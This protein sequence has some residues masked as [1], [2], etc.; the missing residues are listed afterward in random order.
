MTERNSSSARRTRDETRQCQERAYTLKTYGGLSFDAIAKQPD[1]TGRSGS[2]YANASSA[3]AAYLAQ[4]QRVQGTDREPALSVTERRALTDD[5]YERLIQSLLPKAITGNGEAADRVLRAMAQQA[6]LHGL[7]VRPAAPAI[8][9][10]K[11]GDPADEL[12]ERRAHA[13][14]AATAALR[15]AAPAAPP[16]S[17]PD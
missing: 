9:E 4:A 10:P 2:M 6:A 11:G 13:R 7:N 12:A 8:E 15:G 5:R 1:P 16:P 14:A 17:P 3:R